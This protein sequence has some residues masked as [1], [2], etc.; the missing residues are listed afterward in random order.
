MGLDMYLLVIE[1][2]FDDG[3]EPKTQE[4]CYWRKF[5]A[6]HHWFVKHYPSSDG[7]DNCTPVKIPRSAL[8]TLIEKVGLSLA[9][10]EPY[11][12]P[13]TGF[14]FGGTETDKFYWE[15]C[16]ELITQLQSVLIEYPNE[17]EFIYYAWY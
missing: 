4:V 6:L 11:L 2:E 14:F 5:N 13:L 3:S 17:D 15:R 16:Q 12:I 7:D 8:V 10:K 1:E 9:T